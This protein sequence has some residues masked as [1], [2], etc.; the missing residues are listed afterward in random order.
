MELSVI[1]TSAMECGF[2]RGS[3]WLTDPFRLISKMELQTLNPS[4]FHHF[5]EQ[6]TATKLSKSQ[7][8]NCCLPP[9]P[10]LLATRI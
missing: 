3:F 2:F 6:N 9:A 10:E 4:K 1:V 5:A 7:E 8:I